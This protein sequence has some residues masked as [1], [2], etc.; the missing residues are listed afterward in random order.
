MLHDLEPGAPSLSSAHPGGAWWWG[1]PEA[2]HAD[3]FGLPADLPPSDIA[4]LVPEIS[5]E[6]EEEEEEEDGGGGGSGGSGGSGGEDGADAGRSATSGRV[7]TLFNTSRTHVKVFYLTFVAPVRCI[8]SDPASG[9]RVL[10]EPA[11]FRTQ[12]G[13]QGRATTLIVSLRPWRLVE[14]CAVCYKG[15]EATATGGGAGAGAGAG[16][17]G[18]WLTVHSE[19]SEV[20]RL[21]TVYAPPPPGSPAKPQPPA[22]VA[23]GFPLRGHRDGGTPACFLCT[24]GCGGLLTHF[25]PATQFAVDFQCAVGTPVVAVG[26]GVVT[27]V[28]DGSTATGCHCDNLYAWNSVTL[29]LHGSVSGGDVFV[30][31]VHV[32]AGSMRVAVG[33]SVAK[34]QLLCLSGDAGF[35]PEP[36]LHLQ[37]HRSD[38]ADAPTVPFTVDSVVIGDTRPCAPHP[39]QQRPVA[40]CRYAPGLPGLSHPAQPASAAGAGVD[41]GAVRTALAAATIDDAP[42]VPRP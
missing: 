18:D 10:L 36:H 16:S 3:D 31:Y 27:A 33:D 9:R 41:V 26:A 6:P 19:I 37:A 22:V 40:G 25:F 7:V 17:N 5:V 14:L 42:P 23:F 11:R 12:S 30:E 13:E 4:A 20:P 24:Q 32:Q 15:G 34:G 35:C 8:A 39:V 1:E 38:A 29:R 28:R 21:A 2:F